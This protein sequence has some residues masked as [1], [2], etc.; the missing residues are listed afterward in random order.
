MVSARSET[1]TSNPSRSRPTP[2]HRANPLGL[3]RLLVMVL[4]VG[5]LSFA[6]GLFWWMGL[7]LLGMILLAVGRQGAW[8]GAWAA[9]AGVLSLV[10]LHRQIIPVWA[11]LLILG[12]ASIQ[13]GLSLLQRR[14][15]V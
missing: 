13:F 4:T 5:L 6:H 15:S 8:W 10:F 11:A 14:P 12:V 3:G 7:L 9:S 2:R 1:K